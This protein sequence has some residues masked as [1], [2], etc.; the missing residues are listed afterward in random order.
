MADCQVDPNLSDRANMVLAVLRERGGASKALLCRRLNL[1]GDELDALLPQLKRG[2]RICMWWWRK[3]RLEIAADPE[4]I[5]HG[6][7]RCH[8]HGRRGV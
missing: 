3:G 4:C 2:G 6:P 8:E 7:G 5:A 1:T